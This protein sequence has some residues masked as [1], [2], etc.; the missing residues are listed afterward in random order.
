MATPFIIYLPLI[1]CQA[2]IQHVCDRSYY[3]FGIQHIYIDK[4]YNIMLQESIDT[5]SVW[6]RIYK[7]DF[8]Q[9]VQHES[10]PNSDCFEPIAI[11]DRKTG[12]SEV[13]ELNGYALKHANNSPFWIGELESGKQV[14]YKKD[15]D[16]VEND[17]QIDST[18]I[19]IASIQ[20][21]T[22]EM[23]NAFLAKVIFRYSV[24]DLWKN[25]RRVRY[26]AQLDKDEK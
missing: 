8:K 12:Y 25:S 17:P 15:R 13:T 11:D 7:D 14:L 23:I 26:I 21:W 18:I 4:D 9:I 22:D 20:F 16:I 3:N 5:E 10:F 1:A 6:H 24:M 19:L 2:I